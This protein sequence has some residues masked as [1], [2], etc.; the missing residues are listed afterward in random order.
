MEDKYMQLWE[1]LPVS[2]THDGKIKRWLW[3]TNDKGVSGEFE[4]FCSIIHKDYIALEFCKEYIQIH[5]ILIDEPI[6]K[7]PLFINH[8]GLGRYAK[9]RLQE[10]K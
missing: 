4:D 2:S 7:M 9:W 1:S 8:P 6:E 10:G 3:V 5:E